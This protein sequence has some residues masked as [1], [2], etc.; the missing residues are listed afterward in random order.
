MRRSSEDRVSLVL[1]CCVLCALG[2]GVGKCVL[3]VWMVL[4]PKVLQMPGFLDP[5]KALGQ[6]FERAEGG[7]DVGR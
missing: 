7:K 1:R 3:V 2:L 6:C 4:S 5:L